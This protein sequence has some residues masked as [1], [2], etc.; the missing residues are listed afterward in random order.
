MA[1][2]VM[3]SSPPDVLDVDNETANGTEE[4]NVCDYETVDFDRFMLIMAIGTPWAIMGVFTNSILSKLF[5]K[6]YHLR[7]PD[8]YLA[9]LGLLDTIICILY[10]LLMTVDAIS[11]HYGILLLYSIYMRY[12]IPLFAVG[13]IIQLFSIYMVVAATVERFFMVRNWSDATN[14][15]ALRPMTRALVVLL[16]F[17]ACVC[18]RAPVFWEY[19]VIENSLCDDP[20]GVYQFVP[21][22][23]AVEEYGAFNFYVMNVVQVFG[24]FTLL[25]ILNVGIIRTLRRRLSLAEKFLFPV[26]YVS[27]STFEKGISREKLKAATYTLVAIVTGYLISNL[28]HTAITIMEYTMQ[29][30][31]VDENGSARWYTIATDVISILTMV[32]SCMRFPVYCWC[33]RVFRQEALSFLRCSKYGVPL[34]DK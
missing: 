22:L 15:G 24:P 25:T 5:F 13:R 26:R 4:H 27:E 8:L 16:I 11:V 20:F 6:P 12:T 23:I 10:L 7:T 18:L 3:D 19:A 28:L 32:N 14:R 34:A 29:S 21:V 9:I 33:S 17:V 1:A 30:M 31:L 2:V